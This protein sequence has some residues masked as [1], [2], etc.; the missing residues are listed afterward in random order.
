MS[1]FDSP[2]TEVLGGFVILTRSP[3]KHLQVAWVHPQPPDS[4]LSVLLT[5]ARFSEPLFGRLGSTWHYSFPH[6]NTES[7]VCHLVAVWGSTFFPEKLLTLAKTLCDVYTQSGGSTVAVQQAWIGAFTEG[8]VGDGWALEGKFDPS[9]NFRA[10]GAR[11]LVGGLGVDVVLVWAAL[12]LRKRVAVVGGSAGEVIR[13]VRIFPLLVAHRYDAVSVGAGTAAT[14]ASP[15]GIMHPFVALGEGG[16]SGG[17]GVNECHLTGA[18][19]GYA[20]AEVEKGTAAQLADLAEPGGWVGG[21]T[22]TG[23]LALGG[24]LWDVCVDLR[25]KTV[26][27]AEA[28]KGEGVGGLR[29]GGGGGLDAVRGWWLRPSFLLTHTPHTH[30][31]MSLITHLFTPHRR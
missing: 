27:V 5:R 9:K 2:Q 4:L 26:A 20:K 8:R 11:Q 3:H 29:G 28:S 15:A 18:L 10:A 7:G 21:F 14:L 23:V 30:M 13:A 12:M 31:N 25:E 1:Y 17:E 19:G 6:A 16:L 24:Q 22:D